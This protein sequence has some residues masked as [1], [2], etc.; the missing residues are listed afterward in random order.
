MWINRKIN[1]KA[2]ITENQCNVHYTATCLNIYISWIPYELADYEKMIIWKQIL[3][4]D[5]NFFFSNIQ[6]IQ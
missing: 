1:N 5:V 3:S 2:I 6:C 4:L